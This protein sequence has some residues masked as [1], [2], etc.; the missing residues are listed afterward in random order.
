MDARYRSHPEAREVRPALI[1]VIAVAAACLSGCGSHRTASPPGSPLLTEAKKLFQPLPARMPG[2]LSDTPERVALGEELFHEKGL[3]INSTQSCN[4]CH[5]VDGRR[6]GADNQRVSLGALGKPGTRNSPTVINAGFQFV[7]F[8]DGRARDLKEQA[9]GPIVNPVE[10]AMPDEKAVVA[11]LKK[12][13][14]TP[15]FRRAFPEAKGDPVTFDNYAEAVAA[16]ERTLVA[17]T[18]FDRFLE[19]DEAALTAAEKKGLQTFI[20]AGCT[21]CHSG[22][23]LGGQMFQKMGLVNAY[24]RGKDLGRFQETGK[25]EDRMMFKVPMLR[26]VAL[27][28]PYFHDGSAKT[29]EQAV[30]EMAWLQLGKKLTAQETRDIIAFLN[31]LSGEGLRVARARA[32]PATTA[33][34]RQASAR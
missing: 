4:T 20:K 8:W 12:L 6:P 1:L 30:T 7:Q 24:T 33:A 23:T 28:A 21:T 16:F 9:K 15:A 18:R 10:M 14:Y 11:R 19:G 13:G 2:S 5:R 27:T 26:D 32:M 25:P 22:A 17:R 3:S 34:G 31:A 29:L